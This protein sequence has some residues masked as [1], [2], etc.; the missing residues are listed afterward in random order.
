M[1]V[2]RANIK[3]QIYFYLVI[4]FVSDDAIIIVIIIISSPYPTLMHDPKK[5]RINGTIQHGL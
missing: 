3:L 5:T 2:V 1:I 4:C